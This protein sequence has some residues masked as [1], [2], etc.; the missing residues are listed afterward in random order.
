MKH[1][2]LFSILAV[3]LSQSAYAQSARMQLINN[4]SLAPEIVVDVYL[5]DVLMF[6]NFAFHTASA[7][8]DVMAT[9]NILDIAIA[10]SASADVSEAVSTIPMVIDEDETYIGILSCDYGG[11]GFNINF[12][13][14]AREVG[15]DVSSVDVLLY[16]QFNT[17]PAVDVHENEMLLLTLADNLEYQENS[18]Y[19]SLLAADYSL[20][21]SN[22]D[23]TYNYQ[24]LAA[25][26]G[27]M[28]LGGDAITLIGTENF[29][30]IQNINGFNYSWWMATSAG[31]PLLPLSAATAR[32][33]LIHNCADA[34]ADLVDV[35]ANGVM[36]ADNLAFR[37]ATAYMNIPAS[38]EL[39]IA[40]ADANSESVSDAFT[41][42]ENVMLADAETYS[43][44]A[45]GI[46]SPTGYSPAPAFA[47]HTYSGAREE[48]DSPSETHA[49][50]MHGSTDSPVIDIQ[51]NQFLNITAVDNIE[52]GQFQ[53]YLE[54]PTIDAV[55][56]VADQ[57]GENI[58]A[59]YD[60]PFLSSGLDG[61]AITVVVSGFSNPAN[62][63]NGEDV[64]LWYATASGGA[65][66]PLQQI[67][68]PP[69]YANAQ[70]IHN[71][72]DQLAVAADIY[73]DDEL[74][75]NDLSF[76]EATPYIEVPA[77]VVTVSMAPNNSQ[78]VQDA[79]ASYTITL[80]EVETYT[81]IAAGIVSE[82]GYN[83][84]PPFQVFSFAGAQT[85]AAQTAA[86]DI[87][88]FL[89]STDTPA[90]NADEVL[91]STSIHT[92]DAYGNYSGYNTF[93]TPENY[94]VAY[95]AGTINVGTYAINTDL[96]ALEDESAV[97][98]TSGFLNPAN[99]SNGPAWQVWI[100]K[101]DGTTQMLDDYINIDEHSQA[102]VILYPNPTNSVLMF[103]GIT[104][105]IQSYN[106]ADVSGR[107]VVSN[108]HFSCMNGLQIA[109][110][111][112]LPVGNY[113][114][115]MV[116]DGGTQSVQFEIAR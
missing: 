75:I 88:F 21:I 26:F 79:F 53:G 82:S 77:G 23:N 95:Q 1:F 36:M 14:G 73:F 54:F 42:I 25:P 60:A 108:Q 45:N 19:L 67:I 68:T 74:V 35:Y 99:N 65:L 20:L 39:E 103:D 83:P 38:I 56:D 2:Q 66:I 98:F 12:I 107:V 85:E 9:D 47:L 32:L 55:F 70:F 52:Y 93:D 40:I 33:Q 91:T 80:S 64:G 3:V 71:C 22:D 13:N 8:I 24:Q 94:G 57:S 15:I 63:S 86:T 84:A 6:D 43:M 28:N 59:T 101:A 104:E 61:Q 110:I 10:D 27:T 105:G 106:I 115:Q 62:N 72:A 5:N 116:R 112:T 100:A 89:G 58:L 111:S 34:T 76:R 48:A 37:H 81:L 90:M 16:H 31:G 51:E 49:L 87:N 11:T 41:T 69:I 30:D 114:L 17:L 44:V 97:V 92:T 46:I 50:L 7:F 18:G 29:E 78:G 113:L 102:Q 96:L 4:C 109:D